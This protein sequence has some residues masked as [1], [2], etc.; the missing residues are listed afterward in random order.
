MQIEKNTVVSLSYRLSDSQGEILEEAGAD[1]PAFYL[2]G[3]YD[4]IFPAVEA[5]L[6]GKTVGA[7]LSLLLEPEDAFGDYDEN[8][9]RVEEQGAF[10]GNVEVGMQFEGSSED[11]QHQLLYT[12]TDIA[13]GKVVV[14]GNHPLAGQSLRLECEVLGVRGATA[15][16]VSHGHVHGPDGHHQH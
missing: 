12:V 2:H 8:L 9:V 16:E 3:G 15:E 5:A 1:T 13:E 11:G 7:T 4:G 14:D 10:P 6:E